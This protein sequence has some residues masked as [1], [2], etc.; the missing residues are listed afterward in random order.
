MGFAGADEHLVVREYYNPNNFDVCFWRLSNYR[1]LNINK[2]LS[3]FKI[4]LGPIAAVLKPNEFITLPHG[5]YDIH[6]KGLEKG[7][8]FKLITNYG[9][10]R[11]KGNKHPSLPV[12]DQKWTDRS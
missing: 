4:P 6:G 9:D 8:P 2:Y 10:A 11:G 7:E 5:Y 1:S 3:A 12:V